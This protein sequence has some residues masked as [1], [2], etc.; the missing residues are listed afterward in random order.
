[1]RGM[2]LWKSLQE[3]KG[4]GRVGGTEESI[5]EMIY[6]EKSEK[7]IKGK[8]NNK[9]KIHKTDTCLKWSRKASWVV[10]VILP[11]KLVGCDIR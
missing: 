1:M 5:W 2:A 3:F 4:H 7:N 9:L 11:G 8:G 10:A 6:G